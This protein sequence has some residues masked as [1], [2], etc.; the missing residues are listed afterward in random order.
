VHET[1]SGGKSVT[2][3][4]RKRCKVLLFVVSAI[5]GAVL[6][7]LVTARPRE[8][9]ELSVPR[10][11]PPA[12][13]ERPAEQSSRIS[14]VVYCLLVPLLLVFTVWLTSRDQWLPAEASVTTAVLVLVMAFRGPVRQ[15]GRWTSGVLVVLAILAVPLDLLLILDRIGSSASDVNGLLVQL[16]LFIVFVGVVAWLPASRGKVVF[17]ETGALLMI[18][19]MLSFL[20]FRGI[21]HFAAQ[22]PAPERDDDSAIVVLAADPNASLSVQVSFTV[23][24]HLDSYATSMALTVKS[25]SVM[26]RRWGVVLLG[27]AQFESEGRVGTDVT[28]NDSTAGYQVLS[29]VSKE[30]EVYGGS[31]KKSFQRGAASRGVVTLP[32]ISSGWRLRGY[33]AAAEQSVGFQ[34]VQPKALNILVQCANNLSEAITQASPPLDRPDRLTWHGHSEMDITYATFDQG[35]EDRARNILFV[36]AVLLG[37]AVACLVAALQVLLK[38]ARRPA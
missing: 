1:S 16:T 29:G 36:V 11:A 30:T 10:L 6:G 9:P 18:A 12:V 5:L 8:S 22:V 32:P 27:G 37:A 17:A 13:A 33:G 20:S 24:S 19:L 35:E 31:V 25:D 15:R 38:A 3:D 34:L 2:G 7:R 4:A 21:A 28:I 14:S 23:S 26:D